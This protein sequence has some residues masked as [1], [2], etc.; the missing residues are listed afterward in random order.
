[1]AWWFTYDNVDEAAITRSFGM[2][3]RW[4]SQTAY[5][6]LGAPAVVGQAAAAVASAQARIVVGWRSLNGFSGTRYGRAERTLSSE[7]G[8]LVA[9]GD[10][11]P[12][13]AFAA[14]YGLLAPTQVMAMWA[15]RYQHLYGLKATE[16]VEA[17]G[18]V[19][20]DQR[21]Y[22]SANPD[23]IMGAKALSFDDYLAGR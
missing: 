2:T 20:V 9:H 6:G 5:G 19:A 21:A 12:S 22:A 8:P 15:T 7:P 10:R 1:M 4:Y 11:A 23:A 18:R 16:L 13:G 14:P 17:L 3:P